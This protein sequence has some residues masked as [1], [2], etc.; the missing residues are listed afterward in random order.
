MWFELQRRKD[1]LFYMRMDSVDVMMCHPKAWSFPD[2]DRVV[3]ATNGEPI[4]PFHGWFAQ[5]SINTDKEMEDVD[6]LYT[7]RL[8]LFPEQTFMAL[9]L[10]KIP[11]WIQPYMTLHAEAQNEEGDEDEDDDDEAEK[12]Q[13]HGKAVQSEG[14][15]LLEAGLQ[16]SDDL[17]V[18]LDDERLARERTVGP[19]VLDTKVM[20]YNLKGLSAMRIF[21]RSRGQPDNMK[22]AQ[23][24]PKMIKDMA[25]Q[26]GIRNDAAHYWYCMFAL[27]YPLAP[28]WEAVIRNDT[29]LYLHLPT[30][31]LQHVHPMV[32]RFR[33]HLSDSMQNEFLW[34]YRGFVKMKCSE[35]GIPDSVVWCQQ[36]TDYFCASCF[37]STHKLARGK[38]HYPMPIPG[39]RYLT[40]SE[41]A[42]LRGQ[43][44]LLNVGYS[45]TRRFLAR[46][47]QSDKMGSRSGDTW[48]FF[49][50]DTF[51][52]ALAQAPQD[53]SLCNYL[54]TELQSQAE[55]V[56]P[57]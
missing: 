21:L 4:N 33:D 2:T 34:D 41:Q 38:K 50:A 20:S 17:Y 19:D 43:M 24:T 10:G 37:L 9:A 26:L 13:G 55:A 30:D 7:L 27:R 22:Q 42:R 8:R 25:A 15:L 44:P 46:D 14:N 45:N 12:P 11:E 54:S 23:I 49:D 28:D 5:Q 53:H 39:C 3:S 16:D 1:H 36:C 40:Q 52:A 57:L 47:N 18:K 6:F 56:C 51:Q 32:K 29:R 35:C 48:L 31:R